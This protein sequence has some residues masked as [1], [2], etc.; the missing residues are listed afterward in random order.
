M[1]KALMTIQSLSKAFRIKRALFG[2]SAKV[3]KAVDDISFSI[4]QGETFG[5]VGESGSGKSTTGML[6]VRLLAPTSGKII[7]AGEDLTAKDEKQMRPMRRNLQMVFQNPYG[8]LDPKMTLQQIIEEP[9]RIHQLY[10]G[11]RRKR[12]GELLDYVGLKHAYLNRYPSEFSGG[13]RQRIAIARALAVDPQFIVA[14]E[15]VS[16]LDVS[17]QAQILNLLHD[18][19]KELKLTYLFISHDLSVVQY[20]SDRVAVMYMGRI[21]EMAPCRRLYAHPIH[22]YTRLLL[23]CVPEPD[24]DREFKVMASEMF[25]VQGC[26]KNGACSFYPRCQERMEKCVTSVPELHE[27]EPGHFVACHLSE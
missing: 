12:V 13:Q 14:D 3:V 7:F 15:P 16:A 10:N 2:A 17:I 18:L 24:P 9:L 11:G 20:V 6:L 8:S 27:H 21:V 4:A 22:P 26:Y 19:Q 1:S 23:D 25:D 5:L